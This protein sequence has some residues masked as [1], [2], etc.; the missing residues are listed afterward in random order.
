MRLVMAYAVRRRDE[1]TVRKALGARPRRIVAQM[2]IE[3]LV[4]S[5]IG[6]LAG[7]GLGV[8]LK[9]L[10]T[11]LAPVGYLPGFNPPEF[12]LR[13]FFFAAGLAVVTGMVFGIFP[14]LQAR[15][16]GA[17][18]ALNRAG[19]SI[20]AGGKRLR[21]ALI[22]IEIAT[23]MALLFSAGIA[24]HS[25]YRLLTQDLG[26]QPDHL[27]TLS[28]SLPKERY[29]DPARAA[30]FY[31]SLTDRARTLPGVAAVGLTSELPLQGFRN[32]VVW[33]EGQPEPRGLGGPLVSSAFVSA[34]YLATL[35]NPV[36]RGRGLSEN[37]AASSSPPVA[38]ANEAMANRFWPRGEAVGKRFSFEWG[39][40]HA[41]WIEIVGVARDVRQYGMRKPAIPGV[42]VLL[43]D[44]EALPQMSLVVRS[45]GPG[46]SLPNLLSSAVHE[47]D[48]DLPVDHLSWMS[49]IVSTS[50]S[51]T[52][53]DSDLLALFGALALLLAGAGVFGVMSCL[54]AQRT[55]EIG[56]R[57]ALGATSL[58]VLQETLREA[59]VLIALGL[60]AGVALSSLAAR[61]LRTV[62]F[63]IGP[64]DPMAYI[65]AVAG[66]I[67]CGMLAAYLPARRASRVDPMVALRYE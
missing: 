45:S 33:V 57:V 50:A 58:Q 46:G 60:L 52:R 32:G 53:Y 7:L 18:E 5:A 12:N 26:F 27:L 31:R 23:A 16:S 43:P 19:R 35:R 42:Y 30:T 38:I 37:D 11:R 8:A 40:G 25:L 39:S 2:L 1:I 22:V 49:E 56:V 64:H 62:I 66:L 59:A 36:I 61:A 55:H 10:L 65:A 13:L 29:S 48:P 44:N 63:G 14:A 4:L 51:S 28:L 9:I 34:G 24:V 20:A 3:S 6:T 21:Q 47:L 15:K 54:V 41:N 17:A 67:A